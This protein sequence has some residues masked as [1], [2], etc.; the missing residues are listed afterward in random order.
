MMQLLF[1]YNARSGKL[2]ALFDAGHKLFSPKTYQCELCALTHDVFNENKEWKQFR[3]S[4]NLR[5]DFYHTDEFSA[6]FPSSSFEF[7]IILEQHENAVRPLLKRHEI[8]RIKTVNGLI[9]AIK[10]ALKKRTVT[11]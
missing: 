11:P 2:N 7:P 8:R 10:T 4:S 9:E 1:V 6:E 5:M 3:T